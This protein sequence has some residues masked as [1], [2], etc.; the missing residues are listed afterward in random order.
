MNNVEPTQ[1]T[2]RTKQEERAA[3]WVFLNRGMLTRV[4]KKVGVTPQFVSMVLMGKRAGAGEGVDRGGIDKRGKVRLPG[5]K[6]AKVLRELERMG[7]PVN[8]GKG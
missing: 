3:R 4:A 5:L 6:G 8:R 7:A 1:T 2:N